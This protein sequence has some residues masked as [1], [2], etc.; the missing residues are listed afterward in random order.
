MLENDTR[1]KLILLGDSGVGKTAIIRRYH[2]DKFIPISQITDKAS[3]FEKEVMIGD[4]KIILELWDT[5]GQE[6]HR[7][8]TK[9]FIK[10]SKIIILVY[11]VT[12]LESFNSLKFWYD[13]IIKEIGSG[14]V[15]GLAGNKT[16]L[17]FENDYEEE[18]SPEQG[19]KFAE[20]IGASF[21][22]IS[23]K[24][25]SNEIKMLFNN[26]LVKYVNNKDIESI[27]SSSIKL[28]EESLSSDN[29]KS[30]N[31][32]CVGKNK[33]SIN[34]NMIF[35]GC[36]GVGKTSI[37]R[38]LKGN[39][40]IFNLPHTKKNY[41]EKIQY[42]KNGRIITVS[43]QDTNGDE[44][45][46]Q[47]LDSDIQKNK[48]FFFVFNMNKIVTLYAMEKFIKKIDKNQNKV[49]LLGY[50]NNS[51]EILRNE[52]ECINEVSQFAKKHEC[53]Y[54]YITIE[55]IYKLKALIIDIIGKHLEILGG[56]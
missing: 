3:F 26:L 52:S 1:V 45:T 40:N 29:N 17:I 51:H 14:F 34:L 7:S 43:L 23:A 31:E 47:D 4:Q 36:N 32:C 50:Y 13:F 15:L 41:K 16:D 21:A 48:V 42:T 5:V 44:Y 9:I 46:N 39:N 30:T 37:I 6:E 19:K 12:S 56:F 2:E 35:I 33:K 20:K 18:V 8:L 55:D 27:S 49:Y 53:E 24:E 22:L 54:E 28:S 38:T 11:N 25:S 10:N